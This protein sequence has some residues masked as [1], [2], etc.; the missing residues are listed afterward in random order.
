MAL[1][2]VSRPLRICFATSVIDEGASVTQ[3]AE[4]VMKL[5][6]QPNNA[7]LEQPDDA[8]L[9]SMRSID[10]TLS[11]SSLKHQ[12]DFLFAAL[13]RGI[14]GDA[15]RSEVQSLLRMWQPSLGLAEVTV[16]S[17]V[18]ECRTGDSMELFQRCTAGAADAPRIIRAVAEQCQLGAGLGCMPLYVVTIPSAHRNVSIQR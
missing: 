17:V 13:K 11:S 8:L 4:E 14:R 2:G 15:C 1:A 16:K 6:A 7:P 12:V 5:L 18:A 9:R 10:S 3:F